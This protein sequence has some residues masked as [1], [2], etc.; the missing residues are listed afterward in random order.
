MLGQS[1][2]EYLTTYGWMLIVVAVAGSTIYTQ[3]PSGC[4]LDANQLEAG[5]VQITDIGIDQ[6]GNLMFGI[7]SATS[8]DIILK[9]IQLLGEKSVSNQT[10]TE[11]GLDSTSIQVEKANE[12][13]QCQEVEMQVTYDKGSLNNLQETTTIE[14]PLELVNVV[15][16]IL[17]VSGGTFPAIES[18]SSI[19][20]TQTDLC[21]GGNCASTTSSDDKKV[22]RS[23]DTLKGTLY[24]ESIDYECMGGN[25]PDTT[26]TY[27]GFLS[28]ENN[29]VDGTLKVTE[30]KPDTKLC[31]GSTC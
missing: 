11:L 14:L 6:D 28:I 18:T 19:K 24:T 13:E 10:G 22:N 9:K 16:K 4:D 23:G 2:I 21:I 26:G 8:E 20:G 17:E 3:L 12:I 15:S 25:C 31:M 29:T 30:I 27:D 7:R 5:D 1:A